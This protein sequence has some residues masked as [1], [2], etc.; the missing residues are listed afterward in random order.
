MNESPR[1]KSKTRSTTS[2]RLSNLPDKER[3]N[4]RPKKRQK[5]K[6]RWSDRPR[7]K[8]NV[9]GLRPRS[10]RVAKQKRPNDNDWRRSVS[11]RKDW[12]PKLPHRR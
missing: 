3:R 2:K 7:R 11:R 4:G 10:K 9:S 8:Q 5:G 6:K 12:R 1:R